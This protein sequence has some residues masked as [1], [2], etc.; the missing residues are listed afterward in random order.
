M[1]LLF[2]ST[3]VNMDF[4][5]IFFF[6]LS[7]VLVQFH[8]KQKSEPALSYSLCCNRFKFFFKI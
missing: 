5:T 6:F 8:F 7:A 4:G 2:P 3:F 1:D